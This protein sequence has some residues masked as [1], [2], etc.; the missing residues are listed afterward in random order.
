MLIIHTF[1]IFSINQDNNGLGADV[2]V[3]FGLHDWKSSTCDRRSGKSGISNPW[4]DHQLFRLVS[5]RLLKSVFSSCVQVL[6]SAIIQNR[7][8]L[9]NATFCLLVTVTKYLN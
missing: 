6:R 3:R 4:G 8:K 2:T 5:K 9:S 7:A 1:G